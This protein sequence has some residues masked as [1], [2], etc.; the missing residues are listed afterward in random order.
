MTC[1][2][3]AMGR[4]AR[5]TSAPR[6]SRWSVP[7]SSAR[8]AVRAATRPSL[9][10]RCDLDDGRRVFVKAVSPAQNPESPTCSGARSTS[11]D[12]CRASVPAPRLLHVDGRRRLG[13]RRVRV[14]RRSTSA[15]PVATP[16]S[17]LQVV[18]DRQPARHRLRCTDRLR[19]LPTAAERLSTDVRRLEDSEREP[20]S[21][22]TLDDWSA[23]A[24]RRSR[25]RSNRDGPTR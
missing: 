3:V 19:G 1:S 8:R 23:R 6:S 10:S 11:R 5:R 25:G 20:T 15:H 2:P 14:R 9:A 17:S 16:A 18:C 13:R 7:T 21:P 24:S 4:A 12:A 22:V